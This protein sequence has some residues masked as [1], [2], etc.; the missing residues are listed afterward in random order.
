MDERI[1][2]EHRISR[3]KAGNFAFGCPV[4]HEEDE[5]DE[6]CKFPTVMELIRAY[7]PIKDFR[8][9]SRRDESSTVNRRA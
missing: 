7:V 2:R 5:H 9:E 3:L 6:F 4:P 8:C 1:M